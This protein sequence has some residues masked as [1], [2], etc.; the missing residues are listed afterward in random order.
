MANT[1]KNVTE[2]IV[3]FQSA[4]S[5]VSFLACTRSEIVWNVYTVISGAYSAG[6]GTICSVLR[7]TGCFLLCES[8]FLPMFCWSS[9]SYAILSNPRSST[10]DEFIFV[11]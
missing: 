10:F 1:C 8:N 9:T 6:A 7:G 2:I 4:C 5:F 3:Y 11:P